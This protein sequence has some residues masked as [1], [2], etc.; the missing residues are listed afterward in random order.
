[1]SIKKNDKVINFIRRNRYEGGA[2]GFILPDGEWIPIR[3]SNHDSLIISAY[4]HAKK[5]RG[6]DVTSDFR[7][8]YGVIRVTKAAG[9]ISFDVPDGATKKQVET[10]ATR[11]VAT[12]EDHEF[13]GWHKEPGRREEG[14]AA[15]ERER[16]LREVERLAKR[17]RYP[18]R[19]DPEAA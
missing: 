3:R 12:T 17:P 5:P 9:I 8:K 18:L 11:V 1:M 13:I 7:D 2:S 10:A 16:C 15:V 19:P 14:A 4:R 6:W